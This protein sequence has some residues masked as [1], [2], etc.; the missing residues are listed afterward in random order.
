[1]SA[2]KAR[3]VP[4]TQIAPCDADSLDA[5]ADYL[6]QQLLPMRT[7]GGRWRAYD[8]SVGHWREVDRNLY[9]PVAQAVTP[10]GKRTPAAE[11]QLLDL[12]EGRW[13]VDNNAF[14]GALMFEEKALDRVLVNLPNGTL[15]VTPEE[16]TLLEHDPRHGFTR[17]LA[18]PYDPAAHNTLFEGALNDALP[19][20]DDQKLLQYVSGNFILPDCRFEVATACFGPGGTGKDTC[21]IPILYALDG[22]DVSKGTVTHLSLA[23]VCDSNCY[24]LA[25]LRYACVNL[26]NELDSRAIEESSNFKKLVSG[27]PIEAREIRE[28]PF[29]MTP[30]CKILSLTNE[31]PGFKNGT[32]A[33]GRRLRYLSFGRVVAPDRI[34][35]M[36][37]ERLKVACPGVL[38]FVVKGLQMCL[39][40][41]KTPMPLGG[42]VSKRIHERFEISN[43]P[44]GSFLKQYCILDGSLTIERERLFNAF[45]AYSERFGFPEEVPV[46]FYRKLYIHQPMVKPDRGPRPERAHI[47]RGISLRAEAEELLK[48]PPMQIDLSEA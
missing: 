26:C 17:S 12:L 27:S 45:K 28:S 14:K 36:L 2:S 30:H 23:Q 48:E 1:M 10:K 5:R 19:D 29:T 3:L 22:G 24:A 7:S 15:R 6:A 34:D 35:S 21:T 33:E 25:K 31:M 11:R 18:A 13:Q 38:N 44:L 47:V 42:Q 4:S 39:Q 46:W 8:P 40:L 41:G 20:P 16:I 37:K 9:R 32:S 43:D